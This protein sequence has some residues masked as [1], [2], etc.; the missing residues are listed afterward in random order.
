MI[1]TTNSEG[2][3]G[4]RLCFFSHF[5]AFALE[6]N[7]PVMNLGFD[8]YADFFNSTNE[9]LFCR[10]PQKAS[11]VTSN[12]I[13]RKVC[14]KFAHTFGKFLEKNHMPLVNNVLPSVPNVVEEDN[15]SLYN[16]EFIKLAKDKVIF[17]PQGYH[18]YNFNKNFDI[19]IK[20]AE[21]IRAYFTPLDKY[22]C[23]VETLVS[24]IRKSCDLVVGI[25]MRQG[26]DY[27]TYMQSMISSPYYSFYE[28]DI[29]SKLMKEIEYLFPNKKVAFLIC[30]DIKQDKENFSKFNFTF[31]TGHIIEDLYSLAKCDYIVAPF[32]SY[33]AWAAFYGRV[34]TYRI[35]NPDEVISLDKFEVRDYVRL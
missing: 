10:Y 31:G 1:V 18:F 32:S 15:S 35:K 23:N 13:S 14:R 7:I 21:K 9:D 17:A 5:I 16:E 3:I 30:S 8:K 24:N 4:N 29:Y 26:D 12:K 22:L 6:T 27:Y 11:L 28:S 19:F 2:Q 20:H 25:H 33:S 34:P